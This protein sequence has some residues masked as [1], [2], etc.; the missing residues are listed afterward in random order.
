MNRDDAPAELAAPQP[1]RKPKRQKLI[2]VVYIGRGNALHGVPARD[3]DA[4]E[5]AKIPRRLRS[6]ALAQKL[7]EVK[8]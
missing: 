3:M 6:A 5:W 7:Y 8:K 4:D 2:G 1:V